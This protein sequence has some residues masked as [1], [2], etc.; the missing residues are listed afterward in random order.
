MQ[1]GVIYLSFRSC[2]SC[3]RLPEPKLHSFLFNHWSVSKCL[4]FMAACT[5]SIHVFLGRP[6]FLLSSGIHSIFNFG[7]LSACFL[8]THPLSSLLF[9]PTDTQLDCSKRMFKFTLKCSYMFR[10]NNHHH[11]LPFL[12]C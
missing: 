6:L 9:F 1:I 11:K 5:P 2:N 10:F 3:R 12:L 4:V 8:L 7:S